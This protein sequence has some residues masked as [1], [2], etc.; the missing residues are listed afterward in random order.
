MGNYFKYVANLDRKERL[1]IE[2]LGEYQKWSYHLG[3]HEH[4]L[5]VEAVAYLCVWPNNS[6][7]RDAQ[8][9][10]GTWTGQRVMFVGDDDGHGWEECEGGYSSEGKTVTW[11][12]ESLYRETRATFKD[13][14][15]QVL[16]ELCGRSEV[17]ATRVAKAS[18]TNREVRKLAFEILTLP[19]HRSIDLQRHLE[20]E[21]GRPIEEIPDAP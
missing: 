9:L 13:I 11:N 2:R 19:E 3:K 1:G 8:G 16:A 17:M 10:Q 5:V 15:A 4:S 20:T 14:T 18:L 21:W 12:P 6:G 7:H